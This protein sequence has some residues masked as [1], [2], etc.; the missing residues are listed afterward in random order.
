MKTLPRRE[1]PAK[2]GPIAIRCAHAEVWPIDRLKPNPRNPNR[3]PD[4]Q[5]RLLGKVIVTSGWRSPIVVS[6]RSGLVV[7]GHGRLEAAKLAGL[8]HVPVDLQSYAS[9]AEELADLIADNRLAE[10]AEIDGAALE[11]L[12][13]DLRGLDFD[14]ELTGLPKMTPLPEEEGKMTQRKIFASPT[15]AWFLFGI[16]MDAMPQAH[17]LLRKLSSLPAIYTQST[18][19]NDDQNGQR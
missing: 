4:E 8:T 10:L 6:R 18:V 7:K 16:P 12:E 15:R 19:N 11:S 17:G 14:M 13:I 2:A 5:L 9:D 3:H 1:N